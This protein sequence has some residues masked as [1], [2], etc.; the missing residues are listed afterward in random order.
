MSYR[1]RVANTSLGLS[2]TTCL[3]KATDVNRRGAT[4]S[5]PPP[6]PRGPGLALGLGWLLGEPRLFPRWRERYGDVFMLHSTGFA[7]PLTVV[8]DPAE[9]KRIFAGDRATV[10]PGDANSGPLRELVGEQ[11]LLLLDEERHLHRRKQMLSPFH[12]KRMHVYGEPIGEIADA[13]I[14]SWPLDRPFALHPSM[15]ALTLRVILRA[16]F[17]LE[18]DEL[19]LRRLEKLFVRYGNQGMRPWM[20]LMAQRE[21]PRYG[22]WRPFIRTREE[23]DAFLG[24]EIERRRSSRRL[25]ERQDIL[26]LLVAARDEDGRGM[27]TEELRDQLMTLLIAGHETTATGLAWSIERL[28]RHPHAIHRLKTELAEDR[29]DYLRCVVQES[30][31]C[32]PVIPFVLRYLTEPLPIGDYTVPGESLLAVSITLIHQRP[33]LYPQPD[34]FRPERFEDGRTES[35]AWLPFGG[36]VRRCIGA[37]FA[38]FEMQIVL[39]RILERCE[40]QAPDPRPEKPRRRA[41]TFVPHQGTRAVLRRRIPNAASCALAFEQLRPS[42]SK[43]PQR[44]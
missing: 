2:K 20:L 18:H 22:P 40:L 16:V 7:P 12:G 10:R 37:A 13:E 3:K 27:P 9:A 42:R 43:C 15:Q 30:L 17:G 28:L 41:V 19:A 6:G 29:Q 11:S 8:S 24:E 21:L 35:F 14:D 36:G 31:R 23:V 39:R 1:S 38:T 33:D 44:P 5:P 32:R 26:S 4:G 25:A 34:E